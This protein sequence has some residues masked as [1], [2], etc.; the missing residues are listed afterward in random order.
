MVLA[1]LALSALATCPIGVRSCRTVESRAREAHELLAYLAEQVQVVYRRIGALPAAPAGPTPAPGTCC[2][3]GGACA[4]DA[5]RWTDP[6]WQALRFT[7]DGPHRFA[8]SYELVDG[9]TAARLRAE[10]DL[11]CDGHRTIVEVRLVPDG[12]GLRATW[13]NVAP[14]E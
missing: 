1:V 5:T 8:Y 10:G 13:T 7:I 2:D 12:D 3:N 4:A 14:T 11:D 9:G 6:A